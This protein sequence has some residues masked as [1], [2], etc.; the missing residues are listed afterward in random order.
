MALTDKLTAIAD[1][2]RAKNGGA[3]KLTLAQMPEKIAAIQTGTDTGDATAEAR[4]CALSEFARLR[5]RRG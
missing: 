2:I 1:A 3:D 5:R 4:L